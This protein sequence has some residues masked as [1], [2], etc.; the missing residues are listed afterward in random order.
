MKMKLLTRVGLIFLW[1]LLAGCL[2]K[3]STIYDAPHIE[4]RITRLSDLSPLAG[5][6][7]RYAGDSALKVESNP[8]VPTGRTGEYLLSPS[9]TVGV[10]MV[11]AVGYAEDTYFVELIIPA[12]K[13]TL[14]SHSTS[15]VAEKRPSINTDAL[16]IIIPVRAGTNLSG[17]VS[18]ELD[19]ILDQDTLMGKFVPKMKNG[20]AS[21][22]LNHWYQAILTQPLFTSC[23]KRL[24]FTIAMFGSNLD[25]I[26]K[27][28]TVTP[29]LFDAYKPYIEQL[30]SDV[31]FLGDSFSK[32]CISMSSLEGLNAGQKALAYQDRKDRRAH[33]EPVVEL[34]IE[35]AYKTLSQNEAP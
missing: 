1:I 20:K 17:I 5:V 25:K 12:S 18:A 9:F 3:V 30:A 14:A 32:S 4:G 34:I 24:A 21:Y 35:M 13:L 11:M 29:T 33:V 19:V 15:T 2:P 7:L 26:K 6:Q 23:D 10:T 8:I 28:I 27:N 31:Y 22:N 16:N